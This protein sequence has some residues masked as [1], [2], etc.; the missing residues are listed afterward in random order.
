MHD[1]I[2]ARASA[3]PEGWN[4]TGEAPHARKAELTM[5]YFV[6]K[7]ILCTKTCKIIWDGRI[8]SVFRALIT[9]NML[10]LVCSAL[11]LCMWVDLHMCIHACWVGVGARPGSWRALWTPSSSLFAAHFLSAAVHLKPVALPLCAAAV[12]TAQIVFFISLLSTK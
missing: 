1:C 5:T 6:W 8:T 4:L 12:D 10:L 3:S 11:P 7:T 9:A 2:S